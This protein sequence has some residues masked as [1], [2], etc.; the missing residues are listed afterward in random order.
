MHCVL[1]QWFQQKW[2]KH[3]ARACALQASGNTFAH[4]NPEFS[5]KATLSSSSIN[6]PPCRLGDA[7]H[8]TVAL[9]NNGDTP[10]HFRFTAPS[11]RGS[12]SEEVA[13][14]AGGCSW[15]GAFGVLP[16]QGV[17]EPKS[18]HLVGTN[19]ST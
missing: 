12:G 1:L 11:S 13:C 19:W 15:F 2:C 16:S 3:C 14:V 18:Q 17:L 8:Q 10:V 5:P 7:V 9:Y 6:F 4:C